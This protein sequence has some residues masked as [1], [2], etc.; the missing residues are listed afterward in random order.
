MCMTKIFSKEKQKKILSKLPDVITVYKMV[1]KAAIL[2]RYVS[3]FIGSSLFEGENVAPHTMN[4]DSAG[5]YSCKR[6]FWLWLWTLSFWDN[7]ETV[8]K[9]TI[10]KEDIMDIGTDMGGIT[11][12]T[13]KI[14]I[15][16]FK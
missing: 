10:K 14:T 3:C 15:P 7:N 12:R 11:Y 13:R 2:K 9:C 1:C 5:F 16:K 8:I 6:F 4:S